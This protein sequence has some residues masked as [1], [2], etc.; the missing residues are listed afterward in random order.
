MRGGALRT[1]GLHIAT[2][3]VLAA[4]ELAC[5]DPLVI[6]G[7][8]GAEAGAQDGGQGDASIDA[9]VDAREDAA[10][11]APS[12]VQGDAQGD[13]QACPGST[14]E[15]GVA[16]DPDAAVGSWTT[17]FERGFCEYA[18]PVGFCYMYGP[19]SYSV[20]TS[21]VHSGKYAAAFTVQGVGDAGVPGQARCVEQGVFPAAAYYGAWYYVPA[22]AVNGGTWN[23]FHF[24]GSTCPTG[25][26]QSLWDVSLVNMG[27]S[28]GP[29]HVILYDAL[30]GMVPNASAVPPIPIDQWFHLE[31]YFKRASDTTGA[32]TLLQDGVPAVTLTGLV[33]DP[34]AWG[35]W[36]VGNYADNLVPHASTVYVDDV[37]IGFTQ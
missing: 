3:A 20:V 10:A 35:Q 18:S 5:G 26:W 30:N 8:L 34:T 27:S 6:V 2:A 19:A 33:T 7:T 17:S 11:D 22:E 14:A 12:D 23:L 13:A 4:A 15:A 16:P 29:L 25:C 37:T 9:T 36:Y 21:P 31:V 32:I 24:Q 28:S 1:L